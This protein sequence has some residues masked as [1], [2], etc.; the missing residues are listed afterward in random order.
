M[1]FLLGSPVFETDF[2]GSRKGGFERPRLYRAD[3]LGGFSVW[4]FFSS[5]W[6]KFS[7]AIPEK[8]YAIF[9]RVFLFSLCPCMMNSSLS[10]PLP[11][12]K[13]G[14]VSP[15]LG[16]VTTEIVPFVFRNFSRNLQRRFYGLRG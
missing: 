6:R 8:L 15:G 7:S 1:P 5:V 9:C 2:N 3:F 4:F 14:W 13:G 11:L 16:G 10:L 12:L